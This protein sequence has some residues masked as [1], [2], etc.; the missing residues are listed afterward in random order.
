MQ[1]TQAYR[2]PSNRHRRQ[3]GGRRLAPVVQRRCRE[4]GGVLRPYGETG[5]W[6]C[7]RCARVVEPFE[8]R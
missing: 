5:R 6:A 1:S 3:R 2:I 4:C 7:E 8:A